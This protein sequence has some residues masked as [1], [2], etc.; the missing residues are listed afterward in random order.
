MILKK[1]HGLDDYCDFEAGRK[2]HF[3]KNC[4]AIKSNGYEGQ[5]IADVL[6]KGGDLHGATYVINLYR[7]EHD[8][9]KVSV[10]TVAHHVKLMKGGKR[11]QDFTREL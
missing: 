3:R 4:W 7:E 1:C 8:L 9:E 6:E 11:Q 10:S 5:V 2:K